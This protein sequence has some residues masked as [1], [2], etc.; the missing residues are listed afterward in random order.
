DNDPRHTSRK[1]KNW[2]EDHD[3]EVMVWPAQ[4]P[5]LNPI[6]HL[7]FILKRRLAEYPEPPKGIAELWERVE[8]EW[9]GI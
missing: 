4:S 2:S 3:Y 7:W 8:R 5:D 9:E 1:T 6:E